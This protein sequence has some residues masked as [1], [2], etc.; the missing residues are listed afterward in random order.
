M[1]DIKNMPV[2]N[3][4][5]INREKILKNIR[6]VS[7]SYTKAVTTVTFNSCDFNVNDCF[8]QEDKIEIG[9]GIRGMLQVKLENIEAKLYKLGIE[10]PNASK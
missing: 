9:N 10:I 7:E 3:E 8:S 5:I 1:I 2:I 6:L 4:L